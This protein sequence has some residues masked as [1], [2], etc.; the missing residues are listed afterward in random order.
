VKRGVLTVTFWLSK[1]CQFF[2]IYFCAGV[3]Q[4]QQQIPHST[5]LRAGSPGMTT[6]KAT[7][8][9]RYSPNHGDFSKKPERCDL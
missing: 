4:R 5:S 8:G 3:R 7:T 9:L 6:R 2:E 1:I